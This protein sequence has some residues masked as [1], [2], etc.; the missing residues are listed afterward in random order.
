L[1]IRSPIGGIVVHADVAVGRVVETTEHLFE[2]MDLSAVW[3][4]IGILE[5]DLHRVRVGQPVELTLTAYPAE[6]LRMSIQVKSLYLDPR[7]RLG[8]VW[9]ELKN[10]SDLPARYLPGMQ[11]QASLVFAGRRLPAIPGTALV[12]EGAERYVLV[13]TASTSKASTYQKRSVVTAAQS[14]EWTQILAGDVHP[15]DRVVTTGL[16]QLAGLFIQGVLR[17]SP[18]ARQ[19]IGLRVESV[20]DQIVEE[21]IEIQGSVDVPPQ[22]RA[23]AAAQ[24]PGKIHAI[25]IDRNQTVRKGDV[26]AEVLSLDWQKLQLECLQAHLQL[27]LLDD[28]L[29]RLKGIDSAVGRR[30]LWETESLRK[31]VFQRRESLKR[32]LE[33]VGLDV[34][35]IADLL[36]HNRFV[37]TLPV[38]ATREGVVVHFDKVLG[39][40]IK[41]EEPLFEIHDLSQVYVQGHLSEKE[42]ASVRLGQK[43][44]VR[45]VSD[46]AFLQEGTIVRSG[47][48]F[49][50]ADRVS[51]VWVELT[52]RPAQPLQHNLLARLTLTVA[53]PSA[54][55]AVPLHAVVR[56]GSKTYV[57]VR[58]DQGIFDRRLVRTGRADDRYVEILDGL[59][60]GEMIAVQGTAVLQTAYAGI[61]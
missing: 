32:K 37:E 54:S 61:R 51:S 16:H 43:V 40:V 33:T 31:E 1:P 27:G 39:K 46:P 50:T 9:A 20:Q 4:K 26:L 56:D 35:Q 2:I 30:Q 10:P 7:T 60:R 57:F 22:R 24:L 11:G 29:K 18:E 38:R 44:R 14:E 17:L 41:A 52:H 25:R 12:V 5:K 58:N 21:V 59:Q 36:E 8:T 47:Q 49:G 28:T 15:G 55:L 42:I 3:V 13:E 34:A 19:N 48:V 23:W 53:Q 45:L 6:S